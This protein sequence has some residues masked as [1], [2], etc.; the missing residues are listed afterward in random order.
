MLDYNLGSTDSSILTHEINNRKIKYV[1]LTGS[2]ESEILKKITADK[3]EYFHGCLIKHHHSGS[4]ITIL[5][6]K[7]RDAEN[8][9][10]LLS[11][12]EK[13]N[14]KVIESQTIGEAIALMSV[15]QLITDKEALNQLINN[16]RNNGRKKLDEAK[17][18]INKF[19]DTVL[20]QLKEGMPKQE[21][22]F[23]LK[24]NE[25]NSKEEHTN[26]TSKQ[27]EIDED[28]LS[29][30]IKSKDVSAVNEVMSK[31]DEAIEIIIQDMKNEDYTNM[32][33]NVFTIKNCCSY[34]G[35][36]KLLFTCKKILQEKSTK[37]YDELITDYRNADKL[38]KQIIKKY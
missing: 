24:D 34:L 14:T 18:V 28:T 6:G 38:I 17:N 25:I 36:T 10:R 26:K 30:L 35:M 8:I 27:T 1:Y 15:N 3:N 37:Y 31:M 2:E 21:K 7:I 16:S 19:E 5:N 4:V 9:K 13:S 20:K 32:N 12:L 23:V 11:L 29:R 22:I 33:K